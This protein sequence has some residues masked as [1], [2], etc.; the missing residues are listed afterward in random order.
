MQHLWRVLQLRARQPWR[1]LQVR[2]LRSWQ[3]RHSPWRVLLPR[4]LRLRRLVPLLRLVPPL[5]QLLALCLQWQAPLLRPLA[6]WREAQLQ[7][8]AAQL[9]PGW[10]PVH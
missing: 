1:A 6:P 7:G 4:V 3:E 5:Q 9:L 10:T 2:V 8:R